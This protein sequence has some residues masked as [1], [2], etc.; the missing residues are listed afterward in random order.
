MSAPAKRQCGVCSADAVYR[1]TYPRVTVPVGGGISEQVVGQEFSLEVC[2]QH[3]IT[4]QDVGGA[5][6]KLLLGATS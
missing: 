5:K 3:A 4:A 1:A 2:L 6:L